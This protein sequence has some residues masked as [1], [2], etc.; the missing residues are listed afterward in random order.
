MQINGQLLHWLASMKDAMMKEDGT[1]A[2]RTT[3]V[4]DVALVVCLSFLTQC[5][6][7]P[8]S[9]G[10]GSTLPGPI[11]GVSEARVSQTMRIFG[12]NFQG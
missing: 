10:P 3:L 6:G 7:P 11:G 8:S 4:Q 5:L 2:I 12:S 9:D 1:G